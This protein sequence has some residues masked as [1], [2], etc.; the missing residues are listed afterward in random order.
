MLEACSFNLLEYLDLCSEA[1][2]S[3]NFNIVV[4]DMFIIDSRT[5]NWI[6]DDISVGLSNCNIWRARFMN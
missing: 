6:K 5:Q 2:L 1:I 3:F 4:F